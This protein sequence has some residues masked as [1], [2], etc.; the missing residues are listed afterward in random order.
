MAKKSKKIPLT[1]AQKSARGRLALYIILLIL[2]VFALAFLT[3]ALI[4]QKITEELFT[5]T[6]NFESAKFADGEQLVPE[7]DADGDWCFRTDRDFK[8]VQ[9]TDVHLGAG[10]FSSQKDAWALNAIATMLTTDKP[11]LVIVTGDVVFPLPH[12]SGSLNNYNGTKIFINLMNRL[13]IYWTFVF[14][15]HDTEAFS[16]F[17]RDEIDK[18]YTQAAKDSKYCLYQSG[19]DT[20]DGK[21]NQIIKV[22]NAAGTITTQALVT[23]DS[24]SYTDG[25]I[26]GA[27]WKYDNLHENQVNW[28]A[29]KIDAIN[30][31]NCAVDPTCAPVKS[32]AF[33]HIPLEEYRNAYKEY[34]DNGKKDTEHV[35]YVYGNNGEIGT[36][37]NAL[38][39]ASGTYGIYCGMYTD[40]LFE[41]GA[42]KGLQGVFCGHDHKNNFS[43]LYKIDD[44]TE[45]IRLTYGM[46]VDYLAYSGIFKERS[47]RGCTVITVKPDGSFDCYASNYYENYNAKDYITEHPEDEEIK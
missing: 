29:S 13:G 33:F 24:H 41:I 32:L 20:V 25:D 3:I 31:A 11:D 9:L 6:N 1:K 21:G 47:Q 40:E 43:L 4:N 46:S 17:N 44:M 27:L 14:G 36:N 19:P 45:P 23:L 15:N 38:S 37:L 39:D 12:S 18:V 7:K 8:A 2:L 5:L 22:K 26:F 30:A 42:Q 35:T 34:L 28:Y 10:I 16:Y